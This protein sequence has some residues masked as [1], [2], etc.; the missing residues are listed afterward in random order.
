MSRA[1]AMKAHKVATVM[2]EDIYNPPM[3]RIWGKVEWPILKA[4]G[5]PGGIVDYVS[6]V[7]S[8]LL[9]SVTDRCFVDYCH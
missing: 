9:L 8:V 4:S 3:D 7:R 2:H 5:N 6:T 1:F